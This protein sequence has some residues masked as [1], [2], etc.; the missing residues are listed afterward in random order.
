MISTMHISRIILLVLPFVSL[1][2]QNET[3]PPQAPVAPPQAGQQMFQDQQYGIALC[4]PAGW[5]TS[6]PRK[7]EFA[8]TSPDTKNGPI[9]LNLDV[10]ELPPLTFGMVTVDRV[11]GGYID[12][13]KKKMSDAQ[14]VNLPDTSVPDATEHRVKLTGTVDG[15]P[16]VNEAAMMVRGG[17]VYVLSFE[18]PPAAYAE[19]QKALDGAL[20]SI[21]WTTG[22]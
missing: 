11:R 6:T 14:V 18:V 16:A 12:D 17:K 9:Q 1:A 5:K 10:P 7:T 2:C 20:S 15:K 13:A 22:K 8:F 4:Y 19:A 21:K 3:S